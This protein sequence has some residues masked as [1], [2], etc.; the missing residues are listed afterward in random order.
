MDC[1]PLIGAATPRKI[2]RQL[3]F[4]PSRLIRASVTGIRA[5]ADLRPF[6][7]SDVE[8]EL[9]CPRGST[10]P[11][12]GEKMCDPRSRIRAGNSEFPRSPA[13]VPLLKPRSGSASLAKLAAQT[14]VQALWS[15]L[16]GRNTE[17]PAVG[18][19][20]GI[21]GNGVRCGPRRVAASHR[22]QRMEFISAHD[23]FELGALVR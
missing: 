4:S 2:V 7:N 22:C 10:N 15:I 3:Q 14:P 1:G 9:H 20:L 19:A 8:F 6:V 5:Y 11:A 18:K 23:K 13:P 21:R 12:N 16:R 17:R